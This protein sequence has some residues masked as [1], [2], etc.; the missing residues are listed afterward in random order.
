MRNYLITC[1]LRPRYL[2][3]M[4]LDEFKRVL[5]SEGYEVE[6]NVDL[7]SDKAIVHLDDGATIVLNLVT[8][9]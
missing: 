8:I 5:R 2:V 4:T 1:D 3:K 9:H 7:L 6:H